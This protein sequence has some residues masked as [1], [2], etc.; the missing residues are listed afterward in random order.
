MGSDQTAHRS[1]SMIL[2]RSPRFLQRTFAAQRGR[3]SS[4]GFQHFRVLVVAIVIN[5]RKTKLCHLAAAAPDLGQGT[6]HA[7]LLLSDWDDSGLLAGQA[8]RI[9]EAMNPQPGE[10]VYLIIDDTRIAKRGKKMDGVS[11]IWDQKSHNFIHGHV[12]VLAAIQFRGVTIPWAIELW[13]PKAQAGRS[14]RKLNHIAASLI[15]TFPEKFGLK[16]RVLFDAAYLA[17]SVVRVCENRG[18]TWFSVAA[19]NR[20]LIRGGR[21]QKLKD[22]APGVLRYRGNRVRLCR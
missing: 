18:F 7:R 4:T 22:F 21:K 14:Y 20:N 3:F 16:V 6:S 1:L 17:Q 5:A 10:P 11:K 15:A 2:T 19:R 12:V 8:W 13:I 9:I